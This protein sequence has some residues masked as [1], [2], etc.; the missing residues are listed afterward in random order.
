MLTENLPEAQSAS[1]RLGGART[2]SGGPSRSSQARDGTATGR[3]SAAQ[4]SF[5]VPWPGAYP[6]LPGSS[7]PW[8]R[9]RSWC[10]LKE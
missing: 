5:L 4:A 10:M 2:F 1:A 9:V 3:A 6:A 7:L 8:H